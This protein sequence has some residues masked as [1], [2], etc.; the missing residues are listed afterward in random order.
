MYKH[1]NY[2]VGTS[3]SSLCNNNILCKYPPL[4]KCKPGCNTDDLQT[5]YSSI[6]ASCPCTGINSTY[7]YPISCK[8]KN[9]IL[10][11]SNPYG[12]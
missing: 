8:S 12:I 10:Q 9:D 7:N 6:A 1:G 4:S 5:Y 11:I 2:M 3:D